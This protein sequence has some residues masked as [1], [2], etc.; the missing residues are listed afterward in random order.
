MKL[1]DLIVK[2]VPREK[3]QRDAKFFVQQTHDNKLYGYFFQFVNEPSKDY[4]GI[5]GY[6]GDVISK[7]WV[8]P[9]AETAEDARTTVITRDEL[10]KAY[11]DA[12]SMKKD[13]E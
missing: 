5:T 3:I 8:L 10:M 7:G 1:I 12:E 9:I 6:W 11:G 13:P 2:H 4:C